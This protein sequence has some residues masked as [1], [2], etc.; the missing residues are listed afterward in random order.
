M[1]RGHRWQDWWPLAALALLVHGIYLTYIIVPGVRIPFVEAATVLTASACAIVISQRRTLPKQAIPIL[2]FFWLMGL[3]LLWSF[4]TTPYGTQKVTIFFTVTFLAA[5]AP[6]LLIKSQKK[7]MGFIVLLALI[8]AVIGGG[9]LIRG[10]DETLG[11]LGLEG[12]NRIQGG[13]ALVV[14]LLASLWYTIRARQGRWLAISGISAVALIG[15]GARGPLVAGTVGVF[16]LVATTPVRSAK[17][18][19]APIAVVLILI[20]GW[21]LSPDTATQR[22][23]GILAPSVLFDEEVRGDMYRATAEAIRTLPFGVGMGSWAEDIGSQLA[24]DYVHPHNLFMEVFVEGGWAPG[25]LLMGIIL[26][27]TANLW[28]HRRDSMAQLLLAQLAA[29]V[30][31]AQFSGN[32]NDFAVFAFTSAALAYPAM[33]ECERERSYLPTT[34]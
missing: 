19:V 34:W 2:V 12:L 28:N 15:L 1:R 29:A 5:V 27:A 33:R 3:S 18:L 21:Y 17:H 16:V 31:A 22:L 14:T 7:L 20:S 32:I 26:T 4:P 6:I 13:R 23:S 24:T 30:V 11:R 9:T 25:I 10:P 8:G